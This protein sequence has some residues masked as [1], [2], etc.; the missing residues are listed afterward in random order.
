M[1]ESFE[2]VAF[3]AY[4]LIFEGCAGIFQLDPIKEHTLV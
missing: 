3:Q 2:T 4:D 1:I